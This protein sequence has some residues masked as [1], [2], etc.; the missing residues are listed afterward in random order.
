MLAVIDVLWTGIHWVTL[1]SPD[2]RAMST[3]AGMDGDCGDLRSITF[4]QINAKF[5]GEV[6]CLSPC[7]T[8]VNGKSHHSMLPKLRYIGEGR[9]L[10]TK[11][12]TKLGCI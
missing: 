2:T 6:L 5:Q 3:Q 10:A 4:H 1:S 7:P 11:A 9:P 12:D 8:P